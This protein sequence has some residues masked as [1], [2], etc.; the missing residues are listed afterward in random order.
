MRRFRIV[1]G[2]S[3]LL[4][5]IS[6]Q[7]ATAAATG[8]EPGPNKGDARVTSGS[9]RTFFPRNKQNEP[10]VGVV[11]DSHDPSVLVAGS[12]E[13]IDNSPCHANS[14]T[15][16]SGVSDNGIYFSFNRGNSWTEPTY[17]GWSA[18]TGKARVGPIGTVPWFYESGL[19]GDGDPAL[20]FGPKPGPHGF[21]WDNGSRLYYASLTS[22]FPARQPSTRSRESRF[23]EPT[24]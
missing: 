21:S 16:T 2:L 3:V 15:F 13:E 10:A 5:A 22:N 18:R 9:P 4:L 6:P 11:A 7:L 20:A 23:R 8:D 1:F 24:T 17:T 14:C 12:N 19:V